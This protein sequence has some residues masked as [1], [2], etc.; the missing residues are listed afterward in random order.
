LL[1]GIASLR[2]RGGV[3]GAGP[4]RALLIASQIVRSTMINFT[5]EA[6]FL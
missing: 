3:N 1:Q 2:W 5:I 6:L 4:S